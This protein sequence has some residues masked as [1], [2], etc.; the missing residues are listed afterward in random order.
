MQCPFP[1]SLCIRFSYV[2]VF[3]VC[4]QRN[5]PFA[6]S[7]YSTFF[8]GA[9]L[10]ILRFLQFLWPQLILWELSVAAALFTGPAEQ[11][12]VT[13]P[14]E[15]LGKTGWNWVKL[16]SLCSQC[17]PLSNQAHWNPKCPWFPKK[18]TCC[19]VMKGQFWPYRK[20]S[21]SGETIQQKA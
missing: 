4:L 8:A 17:P 11:H 6:F 15:K 5:P 19:Q 12:S 1:F 18:G 3:S 16:A 13:D 21:E 2:N 20:C 10:S 14:G 9:N 7:A